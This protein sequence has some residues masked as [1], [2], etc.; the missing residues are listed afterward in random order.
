M[1][2]P[3]EPKSYVL[4]PEVPTPDESPYTNVLTSQDAEGNSMSVNVQTTEPVPFDTSV[5]FQ[6]NI[7]LELLR[8][9]LIKQNLHLKTAKASSRMD[10]LLDLPLTK[11]TLPI[12][13]DMVKFIYDRQLI[14]TELP[15]L[16]QIITK[17]EAG[18][19]KVTRTFESVAIPLEE[20]KD[21]AR[22]SLEAEREI[23]TIQA[24]KGK[25]KEE[26]VLV[27]PIKSD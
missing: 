24:A 19:T 12:V 21:F 22:I 17:N 15:K 1:K 6:D 5:F 10:E 3:T 26:D 2:K 25:P 20:M 7:R 11:E 9:N 14:K 23:Q 13:A 4:S 27:I 18:N 8:S 16:Q